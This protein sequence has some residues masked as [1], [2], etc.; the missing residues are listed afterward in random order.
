MS[1]LL[2]GKSSTSFEETG[3]PR[4]AHAV[5]STLPAIRFDWR[6]SPLRVTARSTCFFCQDCGVCS[7][8]FY[9]IGDLRRN[10]T[11]KVASASSRQLSLAGEA[12]LPVERK[13]TK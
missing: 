1:G 8:L 10:G 12:S 13:V 7:V 4:G 9:E 6:I 11:I 3:Q 5:A 2:K